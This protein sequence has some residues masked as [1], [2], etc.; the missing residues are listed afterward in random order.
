MESYLEIRLL[1]HPEFKEPMLMGVLFSKLHLAL[2]ARKAGDIGISFPESGKTPGSVVRLHGTK[3][4][5]TELDATRWHNGLQ[6]YCQLAGVK[7]VP[8]VTGWRTV[9]RVQVKSN[10][11]RLLRRSVRKG[12]LTE[13]EAE[14]RALQTQAQVTG[15][16]YLQMKSLS[17]GQHFRL[18]I[19][20]S[21]LQ[22]EPVHGL[23]SSYGLSASTTIPWF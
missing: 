8:E 12:W 15:L 22:P 9:S 23:F 1:P 18:F 13:E 6:D 17:T 7:P 10:V 3:A 14:L 5:L 21:E 20:H 11:E 16:P 2:A 19:Q 4:A